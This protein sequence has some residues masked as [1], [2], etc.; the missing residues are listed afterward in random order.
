MGEETEQDR[1]DEAKARYK[2]EREKLYQQTVDTMAT[3]L[4]AIPLLSLKLNTAAA[5]NVQGLT[6]PP[7]DFIDFSTVSLA[8]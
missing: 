3:D 8:G 6:I 7:N 1:I 5:S 2:A 4:P